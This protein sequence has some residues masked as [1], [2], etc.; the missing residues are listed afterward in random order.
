MS[1]AI[2]V[3]SPGPL[4]LVQDA[5]RRGHAHLGVPRGGAFDVRS[6]RLANRLVG[7]PEQAAGLESLGGGLAWSCL[8]HL[9]IAVTGAVGNVS[10]DGRNVSTNTPV[11]VSPGQQVSL[12]PPLIGLRYYV[13]FAGG[14]D[15]RPVLGSRSFDTLGRIGPPPVA[16]GQV[17]NIGSHPRGHP[18]V[19]HVPVRPPST[20]FAVLP[21]PDGDE[22]A[23]ADLTGRPWELDPQSDRIGVRLAGDP[24]TAAA[25]EL[26]SKP[27]VQGSV[28]LPPNGLPII[29]GPD[30]PTTGGYAVIAV[31]TAQSMCDVAQW[32]GGPRTF[33]RA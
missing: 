24:L 8:R 12:G 17:L 14:I 25:T 7:N 27:M 23:L 15:V 4:T 32:S 2:R 1:E 11:H 13:A 16:G 26:P 5:G 28:Q 21:G 31:V 9:T 22:V 10:V 33:R 19:D 30:H 3:L 6:W 20:S 29:L 18:L